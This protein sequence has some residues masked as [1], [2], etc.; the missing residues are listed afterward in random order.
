M[1]NIVKEFLRP[2]FEEAL[3]TVK[4]VETEVEWHETEYKSKKAL[5]IIIYITER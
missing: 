1:E 4:N 5:Q 2:F 3:K